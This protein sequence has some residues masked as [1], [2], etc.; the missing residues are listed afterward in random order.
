MEPDTPRDMPPTT[1]RKRG[2]AVLPPERL[3]EIARV[4]SNWQEVRQIEPP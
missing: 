1:E 3:R 4:L 2:F